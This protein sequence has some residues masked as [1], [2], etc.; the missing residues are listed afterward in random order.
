MKV[1]TARSPQNRRIFWIIGLRHDRDFQSQDFRRLRLFLKNFTVRGWA[2]IDPM[3]KCHCATTF[4]S[5]SN[6]FKVNPRS[7]TS[8]TLTLVE[9]KKSLL[10]RKPQLPSMRLN[11]PANHPDSLITHL[12]PKLDVQVSRPRRRSR[13]AVSRTTLRVC[14]NAWGPTPT[15]TCTTSSKA[16][17]PVSHDPCDDV[18][19]KFVQI[20]FD[21]C[22]K[23]RVTLFVLTKAL[24][25]GTF[26]FQNT[27]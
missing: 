3:K 23:N 15:D 5:M 10:S 25:Y 16:G 26:F 4:R 21:A 22:G 18:G 27:R 7:K 8:Q 6:I 2:C 19:R 17:A 11:N 24:T 12:I 9:K 20:R 14:W 1:N 13:P